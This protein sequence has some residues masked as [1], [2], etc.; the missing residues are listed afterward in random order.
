MS[1]DHQKYSTQ[2]QFDLIRN[3]PAALGLTFLHVF[4]DSGR[5]GLQLNGHEVLQKLMSKVKSGQANFKAILD[6]DVSRWGQFQD[7]DVPHIGQR[8]PA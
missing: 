6:Y 7:A 2:N 1:T 4:E 5:L 8:E 3:H